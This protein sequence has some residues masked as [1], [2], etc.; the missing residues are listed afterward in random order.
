ML[1]NVNSAAHMMTQAEVVVQRRQDEEDEEEGPKAQTQLELFQQVEYL[2]GQL[3]EAQTQIS[4]ERM[5]KIREFEVLQTQINSLD[6]ELERF[7]EHSED[8]RAQLDIH[9]KSSSPNITEVE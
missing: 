8:L 7:K 2:K 1:S 3:E 4:N 9:I 6:A 5:E